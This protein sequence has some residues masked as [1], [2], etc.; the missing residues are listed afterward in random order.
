MHSK[1]PKMPSLIEKAETQIL[2]VIPLRGT[3]C[4]PSVQLNIDVMRRVSL[5]AFGAAAAANDPRVLLLAQKDSSVENPTPRDLYK[6]GTVA[7]IRQ[8][9]KNPDGNLSVVFE[10][11]ARAVAESVYEYDDYLRASIITKNIVTSTVVP[12]RPRR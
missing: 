8:V 4:F 1:E 6:I 7:R 3:V 9:V 12:E 2:P 11:L 10:G 5:R